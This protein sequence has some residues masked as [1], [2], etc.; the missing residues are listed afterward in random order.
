MAIDVGVAVSERMPV[1]FDERRRDR[2]IAEA[3]VAIS[4]GRRSHGNITAGCLD[5]VMVAL[6]R[7][8]RVGGRWRWWRIIGGWLR[9]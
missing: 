1:I 8:L 4:I 3:R 2:W 9:M 6:F 5:A 7:S